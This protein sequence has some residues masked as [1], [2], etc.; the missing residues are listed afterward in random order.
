MLVEEI[1]TVAP[2]TCTPDDSMNRAAHIFWEHDCGCVPV[3]DAEQH[4]VGMLTDRDVCIAAYTQGCRLAEMPVHTAMSAAVHT[5]LD[6]DSIEQAERIMRTNRVRRLPVLDDRRQLVGVLSLHDIAQTAAQNRHRRH[7][8][9]TDI[10]VA[11][12]LSVIAA[13]RRTSLAALGT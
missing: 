9:V 4:V 7:A 12:T 2:A 3:V 8:A 6:T 13:P 1:M 10:E 11:E 5:C